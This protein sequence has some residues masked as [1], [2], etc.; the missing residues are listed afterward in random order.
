MR[1]HTSFLLLLMLTLAVGSAQLVCAQDESDDTTTEQTPTKSKK[2]EVSPFLQAFKK[3][4]TFN[5][6]PNKK[7]KYY[8]YLQSA[9]WCGFCCKEMPDIVKE[10]K[11]MKKNGVEIILCSRDHTQDDAKAFI[12]EFGIRFPTV[13]DNND[14]GLPLPGYTRAPGIPWAVFV[15]ASGKAISNG[16]GSSVK[17]WKQIIQKAEEASTPEE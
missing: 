7:A 3:V 4:R 6:K 8:I 16:H 2:K 1:K 15:D 11:E 14:K 10:Y 17:N 9:K 12:K 5:G 13:L